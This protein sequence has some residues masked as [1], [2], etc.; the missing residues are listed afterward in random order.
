MLRVQPVKDSAGRHC[1][2]VAI[3]IEV[4][5]QPEPL[6]EFERLAQALPSSLG[7]H[8]ARPERGS[9]GAASGHNTGRM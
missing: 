2:T 7:E 9:N 4:Q 6:A 3:Q 8:A 5:A 1:Y